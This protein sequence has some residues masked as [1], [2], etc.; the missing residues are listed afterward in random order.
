MKV[1]RIFLAI[2]LLRIARGLTELSIWVLPT[3]KGGFK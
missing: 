1:A 3:P 2:L